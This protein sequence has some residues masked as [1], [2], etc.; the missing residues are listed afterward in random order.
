MIIIPTFSQYDPLELFL[1]LDGVFAHFD[2][3]HY[4]LTGKWPHEV[5]KASLWKTVYKAKNFFLTLKFM[6]DAEILWKYCKQYNPRFL[7]GAPLIPDSHDHKRQWVAEKF[8][9]EWETIVLPSKDKQKY[10]GEHKVL[11]DD[12]KD[13]I[14]RWIDAGG[15]GIVHKNAHDTIQQLEAVRIATIS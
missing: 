12:R 14:D 8:G 9:A 5:S 11:V 13:N 6:P 15:I 7:T 2:L 1:D 3:A 10:S 4:E